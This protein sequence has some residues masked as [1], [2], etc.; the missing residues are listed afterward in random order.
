MEE[1]EMKTLVDKVKNEV[2]G[3]VTTEVEAAIE[4][5]LT[6]DQFNQSMKDL[7]VDKDTI[8]GLT[9]AVEAQGFKMRT[10]VEGEAAKPKSTLDFFKS[11]EEAIKGL[12]GMKGGGVIRLDG[13]LNKATVQ[14][15]DITSD[16][17]GLYLAGAD[18]MPN[19][20][21]FLKSLFNNV[22]LG[23]NSHNIVYYTDQ[24][25][26]SAA[27]AAFEEAAAVPSSS[28]IAW[29]MRSIDM[30]NVG[31]SIKIAQRSMDNIDFIAGETDFFLRKNVD[32]QTDAYMYSGTGSNQPFGV[33]ARA[34]AYAAGSYAASY[35][36][37]NL[38]DL[39]RVCGA[40][41]ATGTP[42]LANYVI[43]TPLDAEKYLFGK[44]DANNNY[45]IPQNG[46]IVPLINGVNIVINNGVTADTMVVGDFGYGTVYQQ[47]GLTVEMGYVDD[48]FQKNLVTLK[49]YEEMNLLIRTVHAK[50][51]NYVSGIADAISG[52]DAPTA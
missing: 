20:R 5:T 26:D 3:V 39:I 31:D 36:D 6:I 25:T 28:D 41:V 18:R 29:T 24:S 50:A 7:G 47:K 17:A 34:T 22:G 14:S 40:L 9:E 2:K 37:A 48:D 15:S 42:Y 33:T 27:S 10:I 4:G 13:K 30:E 12:S 49:A 52:L 23:A 44:K 11:N 45:I 43:L 38:M 51:F 32:L 46:S 19:R 21:P 35:Q 1:N 16:T 8:K